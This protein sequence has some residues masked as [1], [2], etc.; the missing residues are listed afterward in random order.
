MFCSFA[1]SARASCMTW[2]LSTASA[3]P[4]FSTLWNHTSPMWRLSYQTK[5]KL[6]NS[7]RLGIG[8]RVRHACISC[9]SKRQLAQS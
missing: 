5:L 7:T 4:S 6:L 3:L 2:G 1:T 8:M 9:S